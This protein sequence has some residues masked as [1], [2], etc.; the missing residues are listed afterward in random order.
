MHHGRHVCVRLAWAVGRFARAAR[1]VRNHT[2]GAHPSPAA[3]CLAQAAVRVRR[4]AVLSVSRSNVNVAWLF[5]AVIVPTQ[6]PGTSGGIPWQP[7]SRGT[8]E[9]SR[10][11]ACQH[12]HTT[13]GMREQTHAQKGRA[14]RQPD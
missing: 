14:D 7:A 11:A 3:V 10:R 8:N 12:T 5:S 4:A 13:K 1:R 6:T 2:L 9:H